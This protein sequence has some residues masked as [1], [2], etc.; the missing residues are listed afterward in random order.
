MIGYTYTITNKAG[1]SFKI[2]DHVTDP[3]NFIALQQYPDMDIDVKNNEVNLDGQ[4]GIWDFF[5]YFGKR[6][7]SFNGVIIGEDEE[8]VE[9]L[10]NQIVSVLALPMQPSGDD[11]GYCTIEWTDA[12]GAEWQIEAKIARSPRFGREMRQNYKLDF[13]LSFKTDNP[14]IL[15]SSSTEEE[16]TRGYFA[17]GVKFPIELPA[18]MGLVAM[19]AMNVVN[20][21][22]VY[23]HTVIR[24][25]GE[26]GG[27]ITN[28]TITNN[29]T[30]KS[31]RI[32]TVL[33]DETEY[34]EI[35]SQSGTVVDKDG[36]DLSADISDDSEFV[37][38][39]PGNNELVYTADE[40]ART[41]AGA[42]GVVF[43]S[44]KI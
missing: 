15:S 2:N 37:L 39:K 5:S 3:E 31:F 13:M 14:F 36:N 29:T 19:E 27:D 1:D 28:P 10:R 11:D 16:G 38:L 9:T 26:E 21:G 4:H 7:L 43:K 41:P 22:T 20:D 24:L 30:G 34:I 12:T 35:D 8:A 23:A 33:A 44:T 6:N 17:Y 32:E 18:V 42:F 25:Y 40:A